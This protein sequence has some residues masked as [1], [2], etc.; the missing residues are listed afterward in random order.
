MENKSFKKFLHLRE[1]AGDKDWKAESK[2]DLE[3]GFIPPTKLR[4]VIRAFVS[5]GEIVL[6]QDTG[7]KPVTMPKK[8]LYLV[9]GPVRDF[10]S[11]K[12]VKDLDLATNA[13]PAQIAIIL[14]AAG[15]KRTGDRSGKNGEE[16]SLPSSFL[17]A[18]GETV[19]IE[20]AKSGEKKMWFVKG[21]DSSPE[22]K[23]FV[24]SAVVDGEEFEIATFRKDAKVVDGQAEVDFVDNPKEDADRRDL[25]YNALYIELTK[26]TG[27][28][29]T[30]YDP[31][32][33]G[34]YDLKNKRTRAVGKPSERFEED[35]VRIMRAIRFHCK[36]SGTIELDPEIK[37]AIPAF[38]DSFS[39]RVAGE[40][41]HDEFIKGLMDADVDVRKYLTV[42]LRTG[43]LDVVLPGVKIEEPSSVPAE[44]TDKRDKTLALAWILQNNSIDKVDKAL[45]PFREV[46]GEQR[47][48]GWQAQERSAIKY[49][50]KLKEF[51][52]DDVN[53][54]LR[55]KEGTGLTQ[56]QLRDWVNLFKDSNTN[57]HPRPEW[58]RQV[59]A[60]SSYRPQA[61]WQS[62]QE[63]GLHKCKNCRGAGCEQCKGSGE[64]PP[65]ERGKVI[66]GM[67]ADLFR[68]KLEPKE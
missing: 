17:N 13:T 56:Q 44:F 51:R 29:K 66:G 42:Y 55:A 43:M 68:K 64:I 18:D 59:D 19:K 5:S 57:R 45:S 49:L 10:I 15:F 16:L 53:Q 50:L 24:I 8:T 39:S 37:K 2:R 21:R 3:K 11:G 65:S 38:K 14:S 22:R 41:I 32:G 28:N 58:K 48:S 62:A 30:L 1:E 25:T 34:L 35:P 47:T 36:F 23:A 46:D 26:D 61:S 31:T 33:Q 40:R 60:F 7:K 20:D 54:F 9:G 67:E 27:E 63:A 12:A 4:S 52:P 6:Q